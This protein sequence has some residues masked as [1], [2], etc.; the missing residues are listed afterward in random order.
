MTSYY[1]TLLSG[2]RLE[3]CYDIAPPRIRQ[4]LRKETEYVISLLK[5]T[6]KVLELGCGYGRVMNELADHCAIVDGIDISEDSIYYG[7]KCLEARPNCHL[8][9]MDATDLHYKD[10]SYDLVLCVQN[11][12][13]AFHKDR[14]RITEE[15]LRV[16][17]PGGL[18]I[19]STYCKEFWSHRIHWFLLQSI[20][21]LIG[22]IIETDP[23]RGIIR[24]EDGFEA[25]TIDINEFSALAARLQCNFK[26]VVIDGSSLFFVLNKSKLQ[27]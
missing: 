12:I 8:M 27:L 25:L 22:K 5:P 4:Y 1:K 17:R 24:C 2:K 16:A 7:R 6:D 14:Y 9:V 13:C 26:T 21:E 20:E 3:K 11:G 19:F 18:V 10:N 15:A 23:E